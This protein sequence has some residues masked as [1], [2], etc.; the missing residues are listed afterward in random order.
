MLLTKAHECRCWNGSPDLY[1][2][3]ELC[4][5][6]LLRDWCGVGVR[7]RWLPTCAVAVAELAREVSDD[8]CSGLTQA[9]VAKLMGCT[10]QYVDEVER[11][12][13]AK[14]ERNRCAAM[15]ADEVLPAWA[16]VASA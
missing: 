5:Y 10:R 12:A 11:R 3:V 14:L 2:A 9:D 4:R 7:P 6:H 16:M 13:L 1:C 15:L 8:C